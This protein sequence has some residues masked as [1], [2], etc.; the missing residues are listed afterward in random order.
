MLK[1]RN[2]FK[3]KERKREILALIEASQELKC[4]NLTIPALKFT[5]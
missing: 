3:T 1:K 5:P 2:N 4:D